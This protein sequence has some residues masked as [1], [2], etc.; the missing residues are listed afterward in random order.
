MNAARFEELLGQLSDGE[1]TP[2]EGDELAAAVR[3]DPIQRRALRQH[4]VLWEL[5]SQQRA[6]ERSADAF[7]ASCRT[8]FRAEQ[9]GESFLT[10]LKERISRNAAAAPTP[11]RLGAWWSAFRRPTGPAWVASVALVALVTLLWLLAPH[12]AEATTIVQGEAVCTACVLHEG[13]AHTPAVRVRMN[14]G[15]RIYYLK[16]SPM[17]TGLQSYFCSGPAPITVEGRPQT[18]GNRVVIEVRHIEMPPPPPKPSDDQRVLFP[19]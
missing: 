1:L 6:P 5:W 8:R 4:L 14:G 11:T 16:P 18:D 7:I 15:T 9:Q 13:H 17:L 2:A 3:G 19:L 10:G 12:R